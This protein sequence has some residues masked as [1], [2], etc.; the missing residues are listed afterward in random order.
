ME[1]GHLSPF[2]VMSLL[3]RLMMGGEVVHNK[4]WQ[5]T[6]KTVEIVAP[7]AVAA[8]ADGELL[9]RVEDG[10]SALSIELVPRRLEVI[11]GTG[12]RGNKP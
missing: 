4:V 8:H 5:G 2:E 11:A 3:P 12:F 6:A 1:A 7:G 10:V 9:C